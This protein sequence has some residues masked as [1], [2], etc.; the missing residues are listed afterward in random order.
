MK[1]RLLAR[2]LPVLPLLV[3]VG[4]FHGLAHSQ[5]FNCSTLQCVELPFY[6]GDDADGKNNW[7]RLTFYYQGIF[8]GYAYS[9]S[10]AHQDSYG[11]NSKGGTAGTSVTKTRIYCDGTNDC[12]AKGGTPSTGTVTRYVDSSTSTFNTLCSGGSP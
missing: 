11:Y 5:S 2:F 7:C 4:Y 12:G 1:R 9:D 3:L 6:D 8:S 10:H